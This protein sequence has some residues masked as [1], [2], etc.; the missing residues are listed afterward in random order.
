MSG[1]AGGTADAQVRTAADRGVGVFALHGFV[2]GERVLEGII[3]AELD[4][5]DAHASQIGEHR[6]V[7]HA[8]LMPLVNHSCDPSCGIAV[9]THGAHD[10][11]ARRAIAEGEEI[12]FDYA[13][14][15][16]TIDHFPAHCRCG[17]AYCRDTI[18][19]WKDLPTERRDAYRTLTA[20]YL[21]EME[22]H[23]STPDQ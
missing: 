20:P 17:T 23:P 5:N 12:T 4:R 21:L 11:I 22:A 8:G 19:G 13:M 18:T 3:E 15:N 16:H 9:N 14:R 7:R 1:R 2:V 10:L 6:F